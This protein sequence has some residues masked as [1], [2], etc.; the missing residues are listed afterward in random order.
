MTPQREKS[1]FGL[2]ECVLCEAE[3]L[4][5]KE[6]RAQSLRLNGSLSWFTYS[7]WRGF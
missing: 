4:N 5:S 6:R 3:K 1:P 7:G 2:L